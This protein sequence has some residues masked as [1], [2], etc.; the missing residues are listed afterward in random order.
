[1]R[2]TLTLLLAVTGAIPARAQEQATCGLRLQLQDDADGR[3]IVVELENLTD[4]PLTLRDPRRDGYAFMPYFW[5]RYEIDD[6]PGGAWRCHGAFDVR[7]P[8]EGEKPQK[9]IPPKGRLRLG[10]VGV[11]AHDKKLKVDGYDP[12]VELKPGEHV[13]RLILADDIVKEN[14]LGKAPSA[15]VKVKVPPVPAKE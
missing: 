10:V 6:K 13:L 1:M 3:S 14:E 5:L 11:L 8:D 7:K 12:F 9:T 2:F 4:K 15:T